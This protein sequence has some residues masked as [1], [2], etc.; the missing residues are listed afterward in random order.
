MVESSPYSN[1]RVHHSSHS[2]RESRGCSSHEQRFYNPYGRR[3]DKKAVWRVR[4]G[5]KH[6]SSSDNQLEKE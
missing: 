4:D 2:S 1:S 3:E 5:S 6:L